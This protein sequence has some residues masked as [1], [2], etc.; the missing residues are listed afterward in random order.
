MQNFP[1]KI[2]IWDQM[3]HQLDSSSPYSKRLG[4]QEA[5]KPKGIL[6][7]VSVSTQSIIA[8]VNNIKSAGS[9]SNTMNSSR[10]LAL[11]YRCQQPADTVA[12]FKGGPKANTLAGIPSLK[13]TKLS[14]CLLVGWLRVTLSGHTDSFY[15]SF[16]PHQ[17]P[18]TIHRA[19][20]WFCLWLII[21][22]LCSCK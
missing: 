19:G 21:G 22:S 8:S 16:H 15:I 9:A 12:A 7:W 3:C 4:V 13:H 5:G 11:P 1:L 18:G 20:V 14:V 17:L 6:R 2:G 10:S